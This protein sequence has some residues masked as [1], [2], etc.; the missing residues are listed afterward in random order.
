[1]QKYKINELHLLFFI[2]NYLIFEHFFG[3]C[4]F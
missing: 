1:M 3:F 2:V 4:P